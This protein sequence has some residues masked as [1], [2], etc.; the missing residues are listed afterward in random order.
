MKSRKF[1]N[2]NSFS[3][4]PSNCHFTV[5]IDL[6]DFTF[7][8]V[9]TDLIF[10]IL[11]KIHQFLEPNE[12]RRAEKDSVL[13]VI[14]QLTHINQYFI[15]LKNKTCAATI[16]SLTLHC[17]IFEMRHSKLRTKEGELIVLSFTLRSVSTVSLTHT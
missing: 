10:E 2:A 12:R 16:S 9:S 15:F 6:F 4:D 5:V 17:L 14:N 1:A 3:P 11:Y 7:R 13:I 8:F